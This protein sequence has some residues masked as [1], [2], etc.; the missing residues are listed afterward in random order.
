MT[1][2][3]KGRIRSVYFAFKGMFLLMTTEDAIVS[4][5]FVLLLMTGIGL[6]VGLTK[7]EWIMQFFAFGL[8]FVAEGMNTTVEALCDF[9][10]PKYHKKIGFIKDIAAGSVSFA[11]VTSIFIGGI[12][13]YPYFF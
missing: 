9:I 1:K 11:A 5:L 7:I 12:I 13:Y 4:Q 10:H 8:V 3:I 2:F 6:Y